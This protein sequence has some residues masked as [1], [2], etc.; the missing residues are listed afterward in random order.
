MKEIND[1]RDWKTIIP[2]RKLPGE[3]SGEDTT[4]AEA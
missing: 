4:D 1:S 3:G 2:T